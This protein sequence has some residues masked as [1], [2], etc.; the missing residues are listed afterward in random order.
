M[1]HQQLI[2]L[3]RS[4]AAAPS[5]L[6]MGRR[7]RR[8]KPRRRVLREA[9]TSLTAERAATAAETEAAELRQALDQARQTA[10]AEAAALREALEQATQATRAAEAARDADRPSMVAS[11]I[12]EVQF[13]RIQ[14]AE[15]ARKTLGRLARLRAAWRGE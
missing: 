6:R 9:E 7:A 5:H 2:A 4:T 3:K 13:R 14:E 1:N 15:L 12:D 11:K 8:Q 10:D